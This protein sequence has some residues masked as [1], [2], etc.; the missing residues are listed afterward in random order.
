MRNP[1]K[2]RYVREL[3]KDFG[4]YLVIFLFFVIL[5]GLVSGY[6]VSAD[7][8]KKTFYEGFEKYNVEDGHIR[9]N[10][11]PDEKLLESIAEK[12]NITFYDL[13]YIEEDLNDT[14]AT[15]RIF[16]DRTEVNLE[17]LMEGAM[18]ASD[19][20]I[21]IDRVF[22]EYFGY[23]IGDTLT[24]NG[25]Q[26]LKISGIVALVDYG[27]LFENEADMMFSVTTFG[28]GVMTDSGYENMGST[29]VSYNYAW[30]FNDAPEN[31]KAA[32]ERSDELVDIAT[33]EIKAYDEELVK[34]A[35][36]KG[37]TDVKILDVENYIL[38]V[39][40]KAVNYCMEDMSS[41]K[42]TFIIFNY[43]VVLILAFVFAVNTTSTLNA[44]AGVIGTLRASGYS[45]SEMVRHY[46]ML[47]VIVTILGAVVGNILGY[48]VFMNFM[49]GVFYANFSLATYVSYFNIEAFL[50]TTVGPVIL[51]ILINYIILANKMKLSPM[52]F[53]RRDLAR[54]KHRRAMLLNKKLPFSLRFR[55]RI[56]FQNIPAFIT[57][58]CGIVIGGLIAVFG[59]MFGPLLTDYAKLVT[60][61]R[62]CD[63]QY[64]LMEPAE[65]K[66]SG[67]EKYC[68]GSL[69]SCFEGYLKDEITVYGIEE[70]SQYITAE[71]PEDEVLVSNS[72]MAKFGIK[73]GDKLTLVTPVTGVEYEFTVG[74]EYTYDAALCIFMSRE[75][76]CEIFDKADDYYSGY[77]TNEELDDIDSDHI[78]TIITEEDLSK[79]ADQMLSSMGKML[80]LFKYFGVAMF[81][82]LMYLITKQIIEKNMQ[83]I[84]MTKI[85]GFRNSE[86][87]GMYLGI[88]SIVVL[89][90]LIGSVFIVDSMLRVIFEQYLY[91]EITGYL[92]YIISP[93]CYV[94]EVLI[95]AVCYAAVTGLMMIKIGRIEK[96]SV[97]KNVE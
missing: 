77:F 9:F 47:P 82:L 66:V 84:A 73:V 56:L 60:E 88:T 13:Q 41:D 43:I 74:G 85:L 31:D 69:D 67:A 97:L 1:L 38:R 14:G 15:V 52:K 7:S 78:A 8:V 57:L 17:C 48:T 23:K 58:F 79:V 53:L 61:S 2:K 87:A 81:L 27:C 59:L 91:K 11:E 25:G 93:M 50:I 75:Q 26:E 70:N 68:V 96:S 55:L 49:K 89:L 45:R 51:M 54:K 65:T 22:A 46:L 44:E 3:K 36:M 40:S 39:D 72:M 19:N 92:P 18:P 30:K 62:I 95:G 4:K 94:K 28:V 33:E 90:S 12:G 32:H 35:Y 34:E 64:V 71:I 16:K 24:F 21:A 20:E 83:S 86:I 80:S 10:M 42:P 29:H 63:Y 37:E 6:L 5:I 76:F